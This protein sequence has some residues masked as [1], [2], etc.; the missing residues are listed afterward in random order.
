MPGPTTAQF[1]AIRSLLQAAPDHA[2]AHLASALASAHA[3][4]V[5]RVR[6]M[7]SAEQA[8]RITRKAVFAPLTPMFEPRPDA[9]AGPA[10]PR[11]VLNSLWRT[12]KTSDA[13]LI[14]AAE[15]ARLDWR[16]GDP[17]PPE[18][19]R[20]CARAAALLAQRPQDFFPEGDAARVRE[21]VLY[22]GLTPIARQALLHLAGWVTRLSE[23]RAA[24]LKLTLKDA[25]AVSSDGVPRLLEILFGHLPEPA[26]VLRLISAATDRASDRY[27]AESELAAFGDRLLTE[28]E[29]RLDRLKTFNPDTGPAGARRAADD[30][31]FV[32]ATLAEFE[33]S[34][35]LSREGPWGKRVA[36]ARATAASTMESRLRDV[37]E[38]VAAA[39]PTQSV[40]VAGRMS[41]AAPSVASGPDP[42]AVERAHAMVALLDAART[43]AGVG[44]YGSLRN[45]I[46]EK[47]GERL[48][49]YADEVV[50][51]LNHG[52]APDETRA[53]AYLEV[54]AQFIALVRD[55]KAAQVVRRRAAAAGGGAPLATERLRA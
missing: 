40:R 53:R 31:A 44:G 16:N 14:A 51:L 33:Q 50:H 10:F 6:D 41:R 20:L 8:D 7:L 3:E 38:A 55:A 5:R 1:E 12:M 32:C 43:S 48:E 21:L 23:E 24:V 26:L 34:V 29:A 19:D 52:E 36:A 27:L 2:L 9:L 47:L 37:E 42:R 11:R 15:E 22:L 30:V 13:G 45:S 18:F 35:D 17:T 28:A 4:P 46:A 25:D 49:G 39:L 54:A